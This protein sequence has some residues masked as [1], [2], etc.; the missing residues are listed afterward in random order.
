MK[1]EL[2]KSVFMKD[3]LKYDNMY[4]HFEDQDLFGMDVDFTSD[5]IVEKSTVFFPM[6]VEKKLRSEP[7]YFRKAEV[8][9]KQKEKRIK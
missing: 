2:V 3:K 9:F 4:T 6:L 7:F 5:I 8:E 1:Q